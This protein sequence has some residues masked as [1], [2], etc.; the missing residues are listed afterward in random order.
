MEI[1]SSGDFGNPAKTLAKSGYYHF[2]EKGDGSYAIV[3]IKNMKKIMVANEEQLE[4][5][6][7][8]L[9]AQD[10]EGNLDVD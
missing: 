4:I 10:L 9:F 5:I 7:S 1:R 6:K 8:L 2:V 3:N